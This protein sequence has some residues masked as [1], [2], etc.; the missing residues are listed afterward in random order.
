MFCP[1]TRHSEV[2]PVQSHLTRLSD[3]A[4]PH[5]L[6]VPAPATVEAKPPP[7]APLEKIW[8]IPDHILLPRRS[9]GSPGMHCVEGA[10]V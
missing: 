3:V 6:R 1:P 5:L 9:G 8:L 10:T 7:G 2:D 4:H